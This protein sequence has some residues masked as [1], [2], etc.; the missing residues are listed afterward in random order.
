MLNRE[1]CE[2]RVYRLALLLTGRRESAAAVIEQ[3]VGA[4]PELSRLDS[5]HLDRLTV[6]RSREQPIEPMQVPG[7]KPKFAAALAELSAQQREAWIFISLYQM[8][9]RTTAKAM[10]CSYRAVRQHHD[11][12][13]MQ[14]RSSLG[15]ELE[16]VAPDVREAMLRVDVPEFYRQAQRRRKKMRRSIKLASVVATLLALLA[17]ISWLAQLYS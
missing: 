5:A 14:M 10:D 2:R 12:G 3:V 1:A 9:D 11:Q 16:Q 17:A 4:Q 8:D 13:E 15:M 7:L 6:L